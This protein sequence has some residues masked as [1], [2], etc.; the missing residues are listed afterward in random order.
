MKIKKILNR[1]LYRGY[2][3]LWWIRKCFLILSN[4]CEYSERKKRKPVQASD[5][6]YIRNLNQEG[7]SVI[8]FDEIKLSGVIDACMELSQKL[9]PLDEAP[10]ESE[11]KDFWRLL[12]AG[13]EVK[14]HPILLNFARSQQF[15]NLASSYL[16]Q[17]AVLSN[18]TLM[19]SYP[20]GRNP[21]HSQLWHL[22]ADDARLVVFY[23]YINDVNSS[24]GPFELIPK[25]VMKHLSV[26]RYFRKYGMSD[27][28][29]KKYLT[30]YSTTSITG[31]SGTMFACDTATTYH[32]GSRCNSA[33]RL[34]LAFRYQTFTGLFP[35]KAL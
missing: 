8:K 10:P 22:D 20:I 2:S 27:G 3:P 23:L 1:T 32:R 5:E 33:I 26:P 7:F 25:S 9:E 14:N 4:F 12:V 30:D 28:E 34:A 29:V 24:N 13:E 11:G 35:F 31:D 6:T 18:V 19:K 16:G 21:N 15:K 17:E